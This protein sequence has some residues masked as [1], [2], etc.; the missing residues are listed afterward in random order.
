MNKILILLFVSFICIGCDQY[1]K[2]TAR[3]FLAGKASINFMGDSF[4]LTYAENS[5]AFLSLG[6]NLPTYL[7]QIIF[8]F[9]TSLFLIIFL[10]F[11]LRS[12]NVNTLAVYSSALILG[13]GIGNLIDRVVNQGAVVD[14]M[15]IVVGP[16]RTGIF[17][18][19]DLAIMAGVLLFAFS[20]LDYLRRKSLAGQS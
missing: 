18:L 13:G 10:F 17:N 19:A 20:N 3:Q 6:A 16:F 2:H 14:F 7:R 9:L 15:V 8:V 5:G 4:R 11:V 1:T 12:Q